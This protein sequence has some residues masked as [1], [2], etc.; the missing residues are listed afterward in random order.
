MALEAA[1]FG[2][3]G[4]DAERKVSKADRPYLRMNVRVGEG[5]G[6]IWISVMAFDPSAIDQAAKFIKGARVYLEGA[7]RPT[8]WTGQD[9]AQRHGLSLMSWHCRLSQIGRNNPRRQHKPADRPI[10]R[11]TQPV[12]F[13]DAIGF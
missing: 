5:D 10:L 1:C 3:L 9:G 12:P 4:S 2:T 6:A 13:D 8:E 11:A 7:L